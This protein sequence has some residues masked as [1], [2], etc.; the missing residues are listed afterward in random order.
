MKP[1]LILRADGNAH[2]GLGHVMRVLALAE[3]APLGVERLFV[4]RPGLP[5]ATRTELVAS[6]FT[7]IE[8][9][10]EA[11]TSEADWLVQRLLLDT[12]VVVLDGYEFDFSY[13]TTIRQ[14]IAFL[15][16]I[17]DLI[18]FPQAADIV[19]N[20][21]G[22]IV[23]D[24]YDLRRPDARVLSGPAWAPLRGPFRQSPLLLRPSDECYF[25]LAALIRKIIPLHWPNNWSQKSL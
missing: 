19:I 1:R 23:A 6:N 15:I 21:A 22:G 16:Y 24:A 2:I 18:A 14:S 9:P 17:D 5:S 13:Q 7:V 20:P 11:N 10:A 25:A 8:I 12:D 3:M 4:V